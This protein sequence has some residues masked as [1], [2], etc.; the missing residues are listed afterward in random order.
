MNNNFSVQQISQ[1]GN[2]EIFSILRHCKI[3][4]MARFM[5]KNLSIQN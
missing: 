2:L 5:E 3:D 4:L 1:T